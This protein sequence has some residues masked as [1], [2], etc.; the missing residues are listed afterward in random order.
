MI[1]FNV[2]LQYP[3]ACYAEAYAGPC[4]TSKMERFAK[5]VNG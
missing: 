1:F 3:E 5:I 2:S 4:E